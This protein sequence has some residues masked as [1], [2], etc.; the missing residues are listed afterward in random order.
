MQIVSRTNVL[1]RREHRL[2]FFSDLNEL[3]KFQRV[4]GIGDRIVIEKIG[5]VCGIVRLYFRFQKIGVV[6]N[7]NRSHVFGKPVKSGVLRIS[8]LLGRGVVTIIRIGILVKKI[9]L[10]LRDARLIIVEFARRDIAQEHRVGEHQT[11]GKVGTQPVEH[12]VVARTVREPL[13]L[14]LDLFLRGV[15]TIHNT[16]VID[17]LCLY[18][19]SHECAR[20]RSHRQTPGN[21]L[22]PRTQ[23]GRRTRQARA[24]RKAIC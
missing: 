22:F 24:T 17:A 11:V 10:F 4:F 16:L 14:H 3:G 7:R 23:P 8:D 6:A 18:V 19:A 13:H 12:R 15:E 9:Q 21:R 2:Q 20:S 5:G 1:S